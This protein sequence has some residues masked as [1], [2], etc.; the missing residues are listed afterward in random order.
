VGRDAELT[1]GGQLTQQHIEKGIVA[2]VV[3]AVIAAEQHAPAP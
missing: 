3:F 2:K 1:V